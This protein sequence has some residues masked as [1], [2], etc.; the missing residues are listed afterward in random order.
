MLHGF[1]GRLCQTEFQCSAH[2]QTYCFVNKAT[3]ILR[4]GTVRLDL[5]SPSNREHHTAITHAAI[6]SA[7]RPMPRLTIAALVLAISC[8]AL[9]PPAKQRTAPTRRCS[10]TVAEDTVRTMERDGFAVIE[11]KLLT[12][13]V[14]DA[15]HEFVMK[16]HAT[17][18][19][20]ASKCGANLD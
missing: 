4:S 14:L 16:R 8:C 5:S 19:E 3:D 1:A 12:R 11:T 18:I 10:T 9:R 17:L 7:R 20:A 6:T 2:T 15:A 13:P